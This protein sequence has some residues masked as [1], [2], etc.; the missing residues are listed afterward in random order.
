MGRNAPASDPTAVDTIKQLEQNMGNAMLAVDIDKLNQIFADD[1]ATVGS[2]GKIIN[3][4]TLLSDLRLFHD[5]LE[6]F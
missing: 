2:S 6:W 3:K 4:Q 5:K 1:W